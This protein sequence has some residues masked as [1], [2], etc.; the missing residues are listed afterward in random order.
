MLIDKSLPSF[1]VLPIDTST[2]ASFLIF[3]SS[4]SYHSDCVTR[5][6][7]VARALYQDF[8]CK[9]NDDREGHGYPNIGVSF[10]GLGS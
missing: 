6:Q 9:F 8:T 1:H 7:E 5:A 2:I 10:A 3:V 4:L